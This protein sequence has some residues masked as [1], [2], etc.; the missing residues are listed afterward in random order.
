[1]AGRLDGKITLITGAS[2]GQGESEARRFAAEGAVVYIVDVLDELGEAAAASI[3]DGGASAEY[4]HLDVTD[5]DQWAALVAEIDG[6][7]HRLDVLVNNAGIVGRGGV[8]ATTRADWQ[9]VFDI[10]VTGPFLGIGAVAPLMKRERSGS[11]I[12]IAS[13]ASMGGYPAS[14]YAAS[15]W[16]LRGLSKSVALEL[17]GWG[18]RSNAIH[19]GLVDTP[20]VTNKQWNDLMIGL[21]P[22]GRVAQPEEIASLVLFLAS[23]ESSYITGADISID[24][25]FIAGADLRQVALQTG[26]FVDP[27]SAVAK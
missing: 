3:R 16:A 20:M 11:I 6:V 17:A 8:T 27:D 14:S 15:K 2:R 10:N 21:T 23:D 18:V 24:G 12:N 22:I 26:A 13:M 7:H 9:R 4:R 1:M 25:G 5:E 19:P